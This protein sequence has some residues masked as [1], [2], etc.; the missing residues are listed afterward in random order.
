MK[1]SRILPT[2]CFALF[3]VS[4][5]SVRAADEP[6]LRQ[7]N[8][9]KFAGQQRMIAVLRELNECGSGQPAASGCV[10]YPSK[11]GAPVVT[12]IHPGGHEVPPAAPALIVAFF[13]EHPKP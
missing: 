8:T 6:E 1:P 4:A 7:W 9:A 3:L 11:I 12:F 10:T 13:Q 2:F 5:A